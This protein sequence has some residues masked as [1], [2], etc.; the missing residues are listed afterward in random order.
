MDKKITS[1][2]FNSELYEK[3]RYH[4]VNRIKENGWNLNTAF[5]QIVSR[6]DNFIVFYEK[7][8][9]EPVQRGR[10]L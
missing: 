8:L 5:I 7:Y 2:T 9:D 6:L 10:N 4:C 1:K 3:N